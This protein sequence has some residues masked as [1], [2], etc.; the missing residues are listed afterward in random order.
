MRHHRPVLALFLA[1]LVLTKLHA[2][3]ASIVAAIEAADDVRWNAM[4]T[5]NAAQLSACLSD[6]LHYAHSVQLVETKNEFITSLTTKRIN[7]RSVEYKTR[8]FSVVAPGVVVMKGRALVKVGKRTLVLVDINFLAVWRLENEHWRLY[9]WQ[10][11]RNEEPI[12]V[13][14][15]DPETNKI[16]YP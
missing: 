4:I 2:E 6:Q 1:L 9:A 16:T 10:S 13:G 7:Y 12:R 3:D 14:S 15:I 5:A 8:D 11:S